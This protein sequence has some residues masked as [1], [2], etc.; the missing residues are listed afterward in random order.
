MAKQ[1]KA[2]QNKIFIITHKKGEAGQIRFCPASPIGP[3]IAFEAI[4]KL[5]LDSLC[6]IIDYMI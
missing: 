6:M 3:I 2:T 5:I 4:S 1:R